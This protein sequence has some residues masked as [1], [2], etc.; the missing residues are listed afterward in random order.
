MNKWQ[1]RTPVVFIIFNRPDTTEKV[2]EEI[3]KAKPPKLLVVADGPRSGKLGETEKC[4][5]TRAIIQRVDWDCEVLTNYSD[6]NLGCKRRVSTGLDWVFDTVEEA[7]I[8]EDD[9]LPEPTFFRFCE[10]LLGKYR[11]DTRIAQISGDNFQFGSNRTE[12]SYYFS[13]I[14][15]LWG[16]A[17]WRRAWKKYDVSMA[18]WPEVKNNKGLH[19]WLGEGELANFWEGVFDSAYQGTID[20]WDFQWVFASWLENMLTIL[21]HLNLISNLGFREDATHTKGQ[22]LYANMETAPMPFPLKHPPEIFRHAAADAKTE[23]MMFLPQP[24]TQNAPA[25]KNSNHMTC[26]ICSKNSTFL[27]NARMLNVHSVDYFKC[28]NCGFIQ[29]EEPYWLNEAYSE[30]ITSSDTGLV[31]RNIELSKMCKLIISNH[32]EKNAKYVDYGGGY[33]LFVRLMRDYGFDFYWLDQHCS[34]L[35]AKTFEAD[36]QGRTPYEL[37]TAFEVFEHLVNPL[38]E[39]E[40]MLKLSK[41][42]FFSTELIPAN[43]PGPEEWWYF[44]LEHGQHISFYTLSTLDVIAKKFNLNLYSNG[45]T[46]HIMTDRVLKTPLEFSDSTWLSISVKNIEWFGPHEIGKVV[47]KERNNLIEGSCLG[48]EPKVAL[49]K[50]FL[51]S[52]KFQEAEDSY[53]D[54]LKENSQNIDT[55]HN[56]GIIAFQKGKFQT[57]AEWFLKAITVKPEDAVA[58]NNLGVVC[59]SLGRLDDAKDCYDSALKFKPG[60]AEAQYN[61]GVIFR[62]RGEAREALVAFEKAISLKPDYGDA[63][64]AIEELKSKKYNQNQVSSNAFNSSYATPAS[65]RKMAFVDLAFH[66]KTKS[67]LNLIEIFK[68][69]FQVDLYWDDGNLDFRKVASQGYDTVIFFQRIY[70]SRRLK[71]LNIKNIVI[72]PM[73]DDVL[74]VTDHYWKQ[75]DGVRFLNFSK[76]LHEKLS[77]LGVESK[78]LQYYISPLTLPEPNSGRNGLSGFL[79]QRTNYIRWSTIKKLIQNTPFDKFQLHSAVDPPNHIFEKPSNHDIQEYKISISDWFPGKTEY[80]SVMNSSNVYF[81][82]RLFEGIGMSFLEAMAMGK[83]VVAPNFPTM[84]E[85]IKHGENGLLY[86]PANPAPLDFSQAD[87]LGMRARLSAEKGFLEWKERENEL[88]E[89]ISGETAKENIRLE[90]INS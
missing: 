15:H 31:R 90:E 11:D 75:F 84:N 26:K 69:Q 46:L 66:E 9:C 4:K 18:K 58:Y 47:I 22:S 73:Y 67:T 74:D 51:E 81:A 77:F 1:L 70:G 50:K 6:L 80:L 83:C 27:K 63:R 52:G 85:Y 86:D 7:I 8:L 29:T 56:L 25:R 36:K 2:F 19:G 17:S 43:N 57:A 60:Y 10:E 24:V 12:H 39:I 88:I 23:N 59:Y 82:P 55:L 20:T 45:T 37:L 41:T 3:R 14:N 28:E 33:G 38:N 87:K 61:R 30:A 72:I 76:T 40:K 21:P 35:F 79:W 68:K 53:L 65:T 49:S 42:I 71:T 32:F 34:N 44:G 62:E 13:R 16:W 78:Y 48:L 64:K 54:F 89:F 5:A